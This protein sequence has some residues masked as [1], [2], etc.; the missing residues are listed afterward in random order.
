MSLKVYNVLKRKKEDFIPLEE[1]KVKM[2]ACGITASGDAHIGHAFQ[3][4]VFDMI[5]KYLEF[6]GYEV[7]YVRNYT[8]VDD[9]IIIKAQEENIPPMEYAEKLMEKIDNELL[10]LNVT[11]PTICSRATESIE[12]IIDYVDKLI[13]SGHAYATE[14]G[15][16]FFSVK[17]FPNYGHFSNRVVEESLSGV[18]KEVEPGKKEDQDFALWKSAKEGEIAWD[19]PWGKGRP[20]WHIECS[21]MSMKFLGETIDIHGGGKDLLFPHHENEIAQSESL[22]NKKFANYWIHNGLIK[23][24]GQKMSKSLNNSI[25]LRDLLDNFNYEV[26]KYTLLLNNYRSDANVMDGMF[27]V[28]EKHLYKMYQTLKLVN[29]IIKDKEVSIIPDVKSRIINEFKEAMDNDFNTSL[30]IANLLGYDSELNKL[31]VEKKYNE[32]YTMVEAIKEAYK[33]LDFMNQDPQT[34]IKNLQEKY[35]VKYNLTET[36]IN[37]YI[38]KRNEYKQNKDYESADKVRDDLLAKGI[39]LMD[40]REGTTWDLVFRD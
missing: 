10:E 4:V 8:D 23:V 33:V 9:K 29:D 28:N 17:S 24:N 19:S 6:S 13:K 16:V 38:M 20:G 27:E 2:Y 3:A 18:R 15:D 22:T 31:I 21:T 11:P 30:A 35:L 5:R 12:D 14:Y 36:E 32:M 37:D 1:G 26:I 25:F 7:T 34:F 40:S 39:S